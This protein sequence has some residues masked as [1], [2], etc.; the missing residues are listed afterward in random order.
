MY[1]CPIANYL[2]EQQ[3][4]SRAR[5]DAYYA[6]IRAKQEAL[7]AALPVLTAQPYEATPLDAYDF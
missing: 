2:G 3:E 6:D 7:L 4:A 5:I 1:I